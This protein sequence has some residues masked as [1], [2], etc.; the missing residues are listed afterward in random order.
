MYSTEDKI[1][2]WE[3]FILRLLRRLLS[4]TLKDAVGIIN[5]IKTN[6]LYSRLLVAICSEM[7]SDHQRLLYHTEVRWLSRGRVLSRVFELLDEL[8]V[9]AIENR[10][11]HGDLLKLLN[12]DKWRIQLAYLADI[13]HLLNGLNLQIQ[14][15]ST[16]H[17]F[18]YLNKIDAFKKKNRPMEWFSRRQKLWNVSVGVRDDFGQR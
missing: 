3:T 6:P 7:G 10:K 18:A 14:G 2:E 5:S 12:D 13:F 8:K 15:S 11:T 1:W 9:F 16:M 4:Q 17:I